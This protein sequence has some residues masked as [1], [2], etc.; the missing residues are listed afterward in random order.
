MHKIFTVKGKP[1]QS[2]QARMKVRRYEGKKGRAMN[3]G[4]TSGIKQVIKGPSLIDSAG[5]PNTGKV[6]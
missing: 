6:R 2:T 1:G 3:L 4:E 5:F